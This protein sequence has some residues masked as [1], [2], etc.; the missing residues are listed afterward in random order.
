MHS[1]DQKTYDRG[2]IYP[3]YFLR[4]PTHVFSL[5]FFLVQL[6]KFNH[7]TAWVA[8][9]PFVRPQHDVVLAYSLIQCSTLRSSESVPPT[10]PIQWYRL[11]VARRFLSL[12]SFDPSAGNPGPAVSG[13]GSNLTLAHYR[14]CDREWTD[15]GTAFIRKK[16]RSAQFF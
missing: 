11:S 10:R 6:S 16:G 14:S 12:S 15:A 4:L 2:L 3:Y 8:K 5:A 9:S 1:A 7:V 13:K